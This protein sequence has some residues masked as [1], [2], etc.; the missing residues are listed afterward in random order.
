M[1]TPKFDP[2][3]GRLIATRA[4]LMRDRPSVAEVLCRYVFTESTRCATLARDQGAIR[5]NRPWVAT[6]TDEQLSVFLIG[7]AERAPR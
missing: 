2:I 6:A 7:I 4:A 1:P 3:E 5:Y